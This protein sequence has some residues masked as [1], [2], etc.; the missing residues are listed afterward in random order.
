MDA[1]SAGALS[2]LM[3]DL[4]G[5][6]FVIERETL[7]HLPESVLLCLF[8]NGLVL[9]R[10]N[11]SQG[12]GGLDD[13]VAEDEEEVYMVDVSCSHS[14]FN[15]ITFA[16]LMFKTNL[17][18][19]LALASASSILNVCRTSFPSSKLLRTTFTAR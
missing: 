18:I 15:T 9:T 17:S 12:L 6:R 3:L 13:Q 11:Q 1:P 5:T 2:R 19:R 16:T 14:D 10:N 8:P 7:M 4:R